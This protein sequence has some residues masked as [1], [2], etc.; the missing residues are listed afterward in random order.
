MFGD[1]CHP[2]STVSGRD[3]LKNIITN[4]NRFDVYPT[5]Y[6]ALYLSDELR[7]EGKGY[8]DPNYLLAVW[9]DTRKS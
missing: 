6:D 2:I 9:I 5:I 4:D 3:I 1:M 8:I 7:K